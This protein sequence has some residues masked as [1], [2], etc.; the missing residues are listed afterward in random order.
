MSNFAERMKQINDKVTYRK[1]NPNIEDWKQRQ[2]Q[3]IISEKDNVLNHFKWVSG[4]GGLND[5]FW[6][7]HRFEFW[8]E[9][10]DNIPNAEEL[11]KKLAEEIFMPY[12]IKVENLV[13][14]TEYKIKISVTLKIE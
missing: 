14:L 9:K 4:F 5:S 1:L 2:K 10:S 13:L 7:P 12:G 8:G 3:N 11:T 6:N